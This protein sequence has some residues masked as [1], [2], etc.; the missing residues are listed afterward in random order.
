MTI[1]EIG[2]V[3]SLLKFLFGSENRLQVRSETA[4]QAQKNHRRVVEENCQTNENRV[5]H[6][7]PTPFCNDRLFLRC[8]SLPR[9]SECISIHLDRVANLEVLDR[10]KTWLEHLAARQ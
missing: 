10:M 4:V 7:W 1:S 6:P 2:L 9:L 5:C 8:S 3:V